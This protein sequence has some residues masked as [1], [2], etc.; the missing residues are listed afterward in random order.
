MLTCLEMS[1][2]MSSTAYQTIELCPHPF[3]KWSTA[4]AD[5]ACLSKKVCIARLPG[6]GNHFSACCSWISHCATPGLEGLKATPVSGCWGLPRKLLL[7]TARLATVLGLPWHG[8]QPWRRERMV[9][10]CGD[11]EGLSHPA[12]Y[13]LLRLGACRSSQERS[14]CSNASGFCTCTSSALPACIRHCHCVAAC[15]ERQLLPLINLCAC[16]Q[17]W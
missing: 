1:T 17:C 2:C 5:H 13:P 11:F 7:R 15:H 16:A 9:C 14:K 8:L 10:P 6:A 3:L 12:V 4:Y